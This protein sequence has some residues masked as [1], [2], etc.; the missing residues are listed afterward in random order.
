MEDWVHRAMARWP[1][2][3]ALYGWLSLDGRG[4]WRI[5]GETISR[6][7]IIDTFNR[8]Y[9]ADERGRWFFQ[10]GPQ[11]G[12]IALARAPLVLRAEDD[13]SL[14]THTGEPVTGVSAVW[15]D[16]QGGLWFA[17][18]QGPAAL[19]DQDGDWAL[20]RLRLKG[21]AVDE[22][23]LAAALALP[24]G[25]ATAL[26]LQVEGERLAVTRLDAGE[27][28]TVLGFVREPQPLPGEKSSR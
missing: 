19:A 25:S 5:Q 1:N 26:T 7:Q 3:P 2:V 18:A 13:G 9:A 12:Y 14:W 20:Q 6:P 17:T 10:N 28:P 15:L 11:R 24:S 8:N 21:K 4:R 16:E 22:A 23:G 27:A